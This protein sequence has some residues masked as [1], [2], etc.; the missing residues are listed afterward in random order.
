MIRL[1]SS[2][3][4]SNS[5]SVTIYS[6]RAIND[7]IWS[8]AGPLP[9][10]SRKYDLTRLCRLMAF[11]TYK[12]TSLSSR[13]IYTPG[14]RGSFFNSSST[15]NINIS[16][17]VSIIPILEKNTIR[18]LYLVQNKSGVC[19]QLQTPQRKGNIWYQPFTLPLV[20]PATKNFWQQINTISMGK[21]L[22]TDNAKT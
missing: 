1:F 7:T 16:S 8:I 6:N 3:S 12:M 14:L 5:E 18:D 11:P 10:F 20:R 15:L 9:I 13:M 17:L 19:Q 22:N 4:A 21:R 2:T